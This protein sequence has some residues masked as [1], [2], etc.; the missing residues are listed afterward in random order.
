[1]ICSVDR[2]NE[3]K[4]NELDEPKR[5]GH[6]SW[7]RQ[8][9]RRNGNKKSRQHDEPSAESDRAVEKAITEPVYVRPVSEYPWSSPRTVT[10]GTFGQEIPRE[11]H[12]SMSR[13]TLCA[14]MAAA[15]GL[16]Q[17]GSRKFDEH[18]ESEFLVSLL[19]ASLEIHSSTAVAQRREW[20]SN[21]IW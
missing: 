11:D 18:S 19:E 9:R 12:F 3:Y 2:E 10:L 15:P 21:V 20:L 8:Q 14:P 7:G 13:R 4:E 5:T 6:A 17:V 1:L 16:P